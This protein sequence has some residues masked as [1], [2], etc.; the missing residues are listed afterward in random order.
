MQWRVTR[1]VRGHGWGKCKIRMFG[2]VEDG[3]ILGVIGGVL[4]PS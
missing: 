3:Y 2:M 1:A 4:R